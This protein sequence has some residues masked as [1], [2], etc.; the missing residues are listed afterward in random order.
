M[1]A[2]S[3]RLP[4]SLHDAARRLADHEGTSINQ[5][6]TLALAEKISALETS[7]YL[8]GRAKRGKRNK[9]RRA[10]GKISSARPSKADRLQN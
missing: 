6:V 7:D 8:T 3:L 5:L 9:F 1:T 2:I 10:L 4:R